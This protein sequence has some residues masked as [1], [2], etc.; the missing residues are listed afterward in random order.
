[1]APRFGKKIESESEDGFGVE[2]GRQGSWRN[3]ECGTKSRKLGWD[4][5][6]GWEEKR[7]KK[8][9]IRGRGKDGSHGRERNC[10]E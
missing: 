5:I 10:T 8:E 7:E 1:M 9:T 4:W 6:R 3:V 2:G